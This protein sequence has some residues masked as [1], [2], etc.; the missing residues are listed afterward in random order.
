VKI[1]VY[2]NLPSGGGKRALQEL[3]RRL[4]ARHAIDAF[5]LTTA[6]HEYCD[7]RP[8]CRHHTVY[9]FE[10]LPLA[11]PPFG[12]VNQGIRA[13]DLVRLNRTQR[14]VTRDI[15]AGDYDVVFV[16]NCQFGASPGLLRSLNTPSV[17]YCAEPP[18]AAIEPVVPR[19]YLQYTRWK[20]WANLLDPF[21][22]I[23]RR[24]LL[25]SDRRNALSASR[26]LANSDYSRESLYRVYG[27]FAQV[28]YLG[29][30]TD[31]FGPA[32]LSDG[33]FV[34][35]VGALQA[36]KGFDFLVE[37]LG[38]LDRATRPGLIIVSNY[39]ERR[40]RWYLEDLAEEH[41]VVV[42][43]KT[44]VSDEALRVLYSQALLVLYAPI[45]EPFG[46]VPLEAMACGTPV[47]AVREAGVRE[48]V[49]H[50]ET[51][52]LA[53]R[54]PAQFSEAVHALLHDPEQRARLGRCAREY[55]VENWSWDAAA[56]R[57][58]EHL[59]AVAGGHV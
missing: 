54:D 28:S 26:I 47:V 14:V 49:R 2:H 59:R 56:A 34:L 31:H 9:R 11:R 41:G 43:F 5:S 15:D 20:R 37:S 57:V 52:L 36:R 58:E 16:H 29:V 55:V 53:P 30:D 24:V 3:L 51:G 45:M 13:V 25:A 19:P 8:Y 39:Q 27:S 38:V 33:E 18:R 17:Y 1:A 48:T 10:P 7:I 50:G 35:S 46:L 42:E 40:E 44:M 22:A 32:A 23:Y 4:S 12:R 6:N 21:P